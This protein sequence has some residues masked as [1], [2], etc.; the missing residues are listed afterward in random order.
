MQPARLGG[1]RDRDAAR[2]AGALGR[3]PAPR[4]RPDAFPERVRQWAVLLMRLAG[5][6]VPW[7]IGVWLGLVKEPEDIAAVGGDSDRD[8]LAGCAN[9]AQARGTSPVE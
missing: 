8:R 6:A 7:V 9:I 2:P 1:S 3:P 4:C 5:V